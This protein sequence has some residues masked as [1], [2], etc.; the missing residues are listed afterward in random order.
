MNN[1]SCDKIYEMYFSEH[2]TKYI[3]S[4]MYSLTSIAL[5]NSGITLTRSSLE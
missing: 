3:V 1:N 2:H 4:F 5:C